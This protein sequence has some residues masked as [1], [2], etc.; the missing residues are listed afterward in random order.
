MKKKVLLI[1]PRHGIWDGIFIRFPESILTIAALPHK[2]GYDVKILDCRVTNDWEK[3]LKNYL[4]DGNPICVGITALTGPAIKDLL[5]SIKII[6][7]FDKNIPIVFGG[8]HATLLPEQSLAHDGI[9]LVVKGEADY[10]FFEIVKIFEKNTLDEVLKSD[11]LNNIKGI[12][13][14]RRTS[15]SNG[16]VLHNS[17]KEEDLGIKNPHNKYNG[18]NL[19]FTGNSPLIMDLDAL[20]DTPYELLDLP[21][22]N[23]VDLGNGV[24]A[25]FQTSRGC[26]FACKFCGNEVLQERKMRTISVSKLVAKIKML[27]N[28]YGY[29]SFLFVDDLTIAGRKHFI[30]FCT[31]LSKIRPKIAWESTGIR[32]NLISKLNKDDIKLLWESGCKALDVGIESGS[33]R[34]LKH[35]QKADTKENMLVANKIIADLPFTTKYTFIVGYPTETDEERNETVEFYLQ[36][37]KDNPNIFPMFF[38]YLPIVGTA[39]YNE[40][41]TKKQFRQPQTLEDWIN[42]DSTSWFYKHDNWMPNSR[43]REISQ[44]MISSLFCSDKAKIKFTTLLGKTA[45]A[46]YHP[47]AKARFKYKFFKLPI[48]SYAISGLQAIFPNLDR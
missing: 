40:I 27:Q 37:K 36:L 22:Y 8:V 16:A 1:Q 18:N 44:I 28:K 20:P 31:A 26:P 17:E 6:K 13:Y 34:M 15:N 23:A 7:Q 25:S 33:E 2:M 47:I 12:Y 35:I 21:K 29:N 45:F 32:A 9:D 5:T 4:K 39:L 10:T 14:N 46:L 19:V 42:I 48:E 11:K 38:V 41:V 30:E 3:V 43:R 24:S